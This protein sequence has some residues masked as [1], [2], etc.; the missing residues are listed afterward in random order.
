MN[1]R[2]LV[3][4]V[5]APHHAEDAEFGDRWLAAAEELLDFLIL[6]RR[7]AVLSEGLRRNGRGQ[8]GGHEKSF[9]CRIWRRG[10][11]GR[12]QS[13]DD[14]FLHLIGPG[15]R[16]ERVRG[17]TDLSEDDFVLAL[18]QA[19]RILLRGH[20]A[21]AHIARQAAEQRDTFTNEHGHSSDGETLNQAGAEEGLNC[22]S[23]VDIDVLD[24]TGSELRNNLRR[25][26]GH[27][28]NLVFDHARACRASADC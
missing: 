20:V 11:V 10:W 13:V 26:T 27:L 21:Q 9:Y 5:L 8:G 6:I 18:N 16:I 25:R 23:S 24:A 12:L 14:E 15:I 2:R 22:D 1:P 7:E 19:A 4:A 3:G 17:P 28:F